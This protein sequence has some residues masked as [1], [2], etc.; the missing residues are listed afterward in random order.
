MHL[1]IEKDDK[2]LG[3]ALLATLEA[4]VLELLRDGG[5]ATVQ[6]AQDEARALPQRAGRG[7][8]LGRLMRLRWKCVCRPRARL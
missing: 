3:Q 5:G 2:D 6:P 1:L 8:P 7:L 4:E